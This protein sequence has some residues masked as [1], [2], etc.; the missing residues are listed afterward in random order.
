VLHNRVKNTTGVYQSKLTKYEYLNSQPHRYLLH[1]TVASPPDIHE[2]CA[3]S[4]P[5]ANIADRADNLTGGKKGRTSSDKTSGR[6]WKQVGACACLC[7][8]TSSG[9]LC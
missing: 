2:S 1:F 3:T 6:L 4:G 9:G 5:A 8:L 7:S